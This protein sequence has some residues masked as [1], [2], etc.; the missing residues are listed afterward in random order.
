MKKLKDLEV[1]NKSVFLRTEFNVALDKNFNVIDD[2][3]IKASLPTIRWLCHRGARVIICSHIGRPWGEA[4]V[5]KSLKHIVKPLSALIEKP[6]VFSSDCIGDERRKAQTSLNPSQI[7][8]LE[9]VR[10]YKE[11]NDNDPT[12]SQ[13]LAEGVDIYINDAF[14][15]SHRPHASMIGVPR[16]VKVKAPGILVERELD[17][18]NSFLVNTEHP[19]VAII[20]GA[21]VAG[22]DGKIHVIRNLLRMMDV[23]CIGGKI[24][25]FF[26]LAKG[27]PVGSTI[28]SDKR[29]IDAPGSDLAQTLADCRSV[30]DLAKEK[31]KEIILPVDSAITRAGTDKKHIINHQTDHFQDDDSALDIGPATV[32][33]IGNFL[34]KAK[35]VVWNGP[36]GYFEDKRFQEGSLG[37][38][39]AIEK[40]H[41][42]TLIGGGDTLLVLKKAKI[43]QENIHICTGGGAMLTLLMGR[44]LPAIEAL[45]TP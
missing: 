31:G 39:R 18:I 44:K 13:K 37:T 23:V 15:N 33:M 1:K 19:A 35:A 5:S 30:L 3:R 11:E 14:G 27:E 17:A 25:Y 10:F 41:P 40:H 28:T 12:F 36:L 38:A 32:K 26:L 2:S 22:K 43:S 24:A 21:K 9:N 4:D 6:I 42:R 7:L 8:L 16:F 34:A 45:E 20:G 29:Q